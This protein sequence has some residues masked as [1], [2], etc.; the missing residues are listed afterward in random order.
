MET[1]MSVRIH[2]ELALGLLMWMA[3][4]ASV[5]AGTAGL[6]LTAQRITFAGQQRDVRVPAG[7]RLELLAALEQP[8]LL[9]FGPRGEL[10][11]GS[12]AGKVYRLTPPYTR[13]EVLVTLDDYPHSIAVRNDEMLI[14]QPR[15]LYRALYR[16]GQ[17]RILPQDVSLLAKLPSGGVHASRSVSVGPD[18]HVYLSLG[19][20]GNCDDQYLDDTYKFDDRRGGVM[21]LRE[22]GAEPR[23][24]AYATGL[25]NPV[26]FAWQPHSGALYASNNGPDH[27]GYDQPPEYF[28]RLRA[29]SFHGMPWFQYDGKTVQRDSS[30][31]RVP[32]RPQG[33]VALPDAT[34]PAHNAPM[35]EGNETPDSHGSRLDL[36]AVVALHGS[37]ATQPNGGSF[38]APSS[39]R[40]PIL[41]AVR[42][43]KGEA[44]RVDDLVTGFQL[45]NGER[46][47]RPVGVAVGPDGA[48]Y[49]TSDSAT[50]GLFRLKRMQ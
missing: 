21:V 48:L 34:N 6:D 7:Y 1:S 8:R 33:D 30:I 2:R 40:P 35:S 43:E 39:R 28:S 45:A 20:S 22:D 50:E 18:G 36:G 10:F 37:W 44:R 46:W 9:T 16:P 25:R 26:G 27:L 5:H 24:Q 32:P 29:D 14:A 19:N 23:W 49:F 13:P 3:T 11:V 12:R 4:T 41:V 15:G 42:F 31:K 47:A 38:G 17:P